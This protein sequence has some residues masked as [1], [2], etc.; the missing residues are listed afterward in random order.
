MDSEGKEESLNETKGKTQRE[1]E[2]GGGDK[3]V[4]INK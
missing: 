1:T 4:V 3:E 2:Q